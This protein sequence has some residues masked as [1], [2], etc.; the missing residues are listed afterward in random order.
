MGWV[1]AS[2]RVNKTAIVS[3]MAL[4]AAA[5]ALHC[6]SLESVYMGNMAAQVPVALRTHVS[7]QCHLPARMRLRAMALWL[8]WATLVCVGARERGRRL[9]RREIGCTEGCTGR[10][11]GGSD[12]FR[13][14]R[15]EGRAPTCKVLR[16]V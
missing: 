10:A 13:G 8:M 7:R 9:V 15:C 4:K 6:T 12:G 5:A 16:L 14:A 11:G 1:P 2:N 3:Y